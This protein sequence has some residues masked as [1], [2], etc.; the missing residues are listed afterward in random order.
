MLT[1]NIDLADIEAHH[2]SVW[3][4]NLEMSEK[5]LG[6]RNKEQLKLRIE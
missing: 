3:D 5:N 1:K 6:N 2:I 4:H